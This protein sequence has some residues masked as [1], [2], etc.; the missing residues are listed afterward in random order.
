MLG[1]MF[2]GY[3]YK[4]DVLVNTLQSLVNI[5]PW[6]SNRN[7]SNCSTK[8]LEIFLH[9]FVDADPD[10]WS[11]RKKWI[12]IQALNIFFFDAPLVKVNSAYMKHKVWPRQPCCI[13]WSCWL[14]SLLTQCPCGTGQTGTGKVD[15]ALKLKCTPA[16][17]DKAVVLL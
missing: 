12:L 13:G 15:P 4:S 8:C 11:T 2:Q 14:S 5:Y 1:Y 16:A 3:L 17:H 6:Y 7:Y 10:P 9:F